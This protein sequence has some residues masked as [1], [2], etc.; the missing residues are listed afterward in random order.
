MKGSRARFA[1]LRYFFP[2]T[3]DLHLMLMTMLLS[4]N[5]PSILLHEHGP[6]GW[7]CCGVAVWRSS[8]KNASLESTSLHP[9]NGIA[10]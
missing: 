6:G 10:Y 9:L 3:N 5:Y 7:P 2:F 4:M 1:S 8:L